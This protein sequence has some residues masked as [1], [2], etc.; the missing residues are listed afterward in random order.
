MIWT[1]VLSL[2]LIQP[3]APIAAAVPAKPQVNNGSLRRADMVGKWTMTVEKSTSELEFY[4]SGRYEAKRD[5][6]DYV[7]V[8]IMTSEGRYLSIVEKD[9]KTNKVR[10][11][12]VYIDSTNPVKG[13]LYE[14]NGRSSETKIF[15]LEKKK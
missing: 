6:N 4:L 10:R 8:W 14:S 13:R 1:Y 9:K 12:F 5:G 15:K 7:G 3:V 11:Y 2:F